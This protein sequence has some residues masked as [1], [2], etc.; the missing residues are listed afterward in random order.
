MGRFQL[1]LAAFL[2]LFY[3]EEGIWSI[4]MVGVVWLGLQIKLEK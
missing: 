3:V 4:F 2:R 1:F